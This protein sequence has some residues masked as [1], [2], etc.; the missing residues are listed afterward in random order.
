MN[1]TR[2]RTLARAGV[3]TATLTALLATSTPGA[4]AAVDP[5]D[6]V[7]RADVIR[8]FPAFK[9]NDW[10]GTRSTRDRVLPYPDPEVCSTPAEVTGRSGRSYGTGFGV[11]EMKETFNTYLVEFQRTGQ[12]KAILSSARTYVT[13]CAQHWAG[14]NVTVRPARLPRLGDQRVAFR[15]V[16]YYAAGPQE[17]TTV[18]VRVG[19]R[20]LVTRIMQP[21]TV[22]ARKLAQISRIAVRRMG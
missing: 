6:V 3:V 4:Q 10:L 14:L 8:V 9:H 20:V 15:S 21:T 16:A 1:H 2:P 11:S 12:A 18:V 7:D 5:G 19:R 13:A 17:T 22:K